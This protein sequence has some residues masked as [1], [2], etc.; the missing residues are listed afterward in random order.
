MIKVVVR[1]LCLLSGMAVLLW[2]SGCGGAVIDHPIISTPSPP[3]SG[4]RAPRDPRGVYERALSEIGEKCFA[5]RTAELA[6]EPQRPLS[7]F[8]IPRDGASSGDTRRATRASGLPALLSSSFLDTRG[9]LSFADAPAPQAR[10]QNAQKLKAVRDLVLLGQLADIEAVRFVKQPRPELILVGP[11]AEEG[12]G[13]QYDDWLTML[14][15]L[16][17]YGPPG[18]SIDPGPSS[19]EMVVRY[20]GGIEQTHLGGVFFEADR[21]LKLL[22]TGYDNLNCSKVSL[23]PTSS[24]SELQLLEQE[25]VKTREAGPAGW[26][27][28]WFDLTNDEVEVSPDNLTARIP[29]RRLFVDEQ[30]IGPASAS[31]RSGKQFADQVSNLFLDLGSKVPSFAGLQQQ[32]GLW[33][34]AKWIAD[35]QIPI[36]LRWLDVGPD[37][38]STAKSTPTITVTRSSVVGQSYLRVGIFGGVDFRRGTP[39]KTASGQSDLLRAAE[40]PDQKPTSWDFQFNGQRYRAIRIRYQK[41]GA[42]R[43]ASPTWERPLFEV[44]PILRYVLTLPTIEQA[45]RELAGGVGRCGSVGAYNVVLR[46]EAYIWDKTTD[47]VEKTVFDRIAQDLRGTDA[48]KPLTVF[49][50][51]NRNQVQVGTY[52]VSRQPAYRESLDVAMFYWPS[53]ECVGTTHV[54]GGDPPRTRPVQYVPGYGSSVKLADWISGL[55]R[56]AGR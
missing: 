9:G 19:D 25:F 40:Q 55:R 38:V 56:E 6:F 39:Y 13:L 50:I 18:V 8:T 11:A 30:A 45:S 29:H 26:H 49:V 14:R 42:L 52:T 22:S 23:L 47:S 37:P 3:V 32:A 53:G 48:M 15:A 2:L 31:L 54:D 41:A 27:R 46:G 17:Q 34:V 33:R 44:P 51:Y 1:A 43:V 4:Y 21:T 12:H 28:F 35:K 10:P 16:G 36:D 7:P 5:G 20:F 24:P